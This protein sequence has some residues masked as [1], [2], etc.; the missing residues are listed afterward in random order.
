LIKVRGIK[1]LLSEQVKVL[2][3]WLDLKLK[4]QAYTRVAQQ[5]GL[6]ALGA[7]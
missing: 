6:A 3:V 4:W 2:R 1:K 7:F 5:K